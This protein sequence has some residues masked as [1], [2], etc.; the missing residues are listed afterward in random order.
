MTFFT[1]FNKESKRFTLTSTGDVGNPNVEEFEDAEAL[2][3]KVKRLEE[4]G[5]KV[6]ISP[7]VVADNVLL[8]V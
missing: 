6:L 4:N 3:Y 5:H 2:D 1:G 7:V 8:I